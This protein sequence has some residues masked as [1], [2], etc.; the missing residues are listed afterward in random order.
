MGEP[1]TEELTKIFSAITILSS[2]SI[3]FAGQ[4][5]PQF[6]ATKQQVP[7][8][9][10]SQDPMVT[11]LQMALYQHCYVKRF[12]G[13]FQ[14]Q[15]HIAV[16]PDNLLQLLSESN[17]SRE[18]WDS[19]WRIHRVLPSG[20]ILAHKN[21][22][23]RLL[24]AGEFV[25]HEGPGV[26]PREGA[27]ISVFVPRES[28]TLQPGFYFAFGEAITDQQDDYN[29]VRLYWHVSGAHIA[30]LIGL[31]TQS[32]NR[33]QIP[34]RLK[35]PNSI[36]LYKRV[37][38]A[39]LYISPRFYRVAAEMLV[40]VH[41]KMLDRLQPETPI[42][43]KQL[44]RGLG[45]AED[46]GNGESFGMHR[47]RIVAEAIWQAYTQG[48]QTEQARLE[49]VVNQFASYGLSLERPYLNA[50]SDDQYDLPEWQS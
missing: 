42:F 10:P 4:V 30:E 6:D 44:A 27:N 50:R 31:I 21:G 28:K 38:T 19:G 12:N 24:W 5:A 8:L 20:Q 2:T 13:D 47:C 11:Q 25:S 33:F 45:L 48:L 14:P 23:V 34:Y 9:S 22:L 15:Q 36:A 1:L 17:A 18:R 7:G 37:D 16:Q 41:H 39:V 29:V 40:D 49:Q 35:C 26:S 43:T 46:P 32:L 3:A